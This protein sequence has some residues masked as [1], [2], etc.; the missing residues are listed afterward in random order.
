MKEHKK[1]YKS[2]KLWMT[3]TIMA[4]A[5]GT[6]MA[7][8][9]AHADAT[10]VTNTTSESQTTDQQKATLQKDIQDKQQQ[11]SDK[12]SQAA[13]L[14]SKIDGYKS[15][16]NDENT[17]YQNEQAQI[18][19]DAADKATSVDSQ[20]NGVNTSL[21]GAKQ[22]VSNTQSQ[23]NNVNSQI[24]DLQKAQGTTTSTDSNI[25]NVPNGQ[26]D[27]S[28]SLLENAARND[29]WDN[30]YS[31][32]QSASS[33]NKKAIPQNI[34]ISPDNNKTTNHGVTAPIDFTNDYN[35]YSD[36]DQV[37][38]NTG[39]T[40]NQMRELSILLLNEL[41]H[42]REQRGLAPFVMT[43]DQFKRAMARAQQSSAA[44]LNHNESDMDAAL[45][46]WHSEN[47]AF[48][49]TNNGDNMMSLLYNANDS[50][51]SMLMADADSD[52]GHRDNFLDNGNYN[53]AFGFKL[54][55]NGYYLMTFDTTYAT[56]ADKSNDLVTNTINSYA[57][58]GPTKG[59]TITV[60]NTAKINQLKDQLASLNQSLIAK[61]NQV[62]TLQ[63][64]LNDLNNQKSK[65]SSD[66]Q[67]KLAD[68]TTKHNAK[69]TD[70]NDQISTNQSKLDQL[71]ND[72]KDLKVVIAQDQ[73]AL[74]NLNKGGQT[75]VETKKDNEKYTNLDPSLVMKVNV[76]AGDT[77]IPAPKLADDAFIKDTNA[78]TASAAMFM[79]LAQT[80]GTYPEGT[81]VEWAD[82]AKVQKD[83]QTAGTYDEEVIL[84]FPDGTK[85]Q[86][87][88]VPGV[89]VVAAKQT[90][91]STDPTKP[92][93]GDDTHTTNPTK[94]TATEHT[95]TV[96]YIEVTGYAPDGKE[97]T[98][99]VGTQTF[100]G[101]QGDTFS[102]SQLNI[103]AG[104]KLA[105]DGVS[106]TIG[107]QDETNNTPV[108]S[109]NTPS[110]DHNN[111]PSTNPTTPTDNK[112]TDH[113]AATQLPAGAKVVNNQVVDAN[114]NVIAGWKVVNG[115]AVKSTDQ[116]VMTR[117]AYKAQQANNNTKALPQTGNND[118][119][120]VMGLGAA[121]L[122]GMFGLIGV[123]KKRN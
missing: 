19:K 2:G 22:D 33:W 48:V 117:E 26:I 99:V 78:N 80:N 108:V 70:L 12:A 47:L 10:L 23:I 73:T 72:I 49:S 110:D 42:A 62:N 77:N 71:N 120:A 93:T 69:L 113:N 79:V 98:K 37:N 34:Y 63:S 51:S 3:A 101:K 41:N 116:P 68:S 104:Y 50:I 81:K 122:L 75:P 53:A 67:T 118:N 89:L 15:Q 20:I 9:T 44:N 6:T 40:E 103:P 36:I 85:S 18:K 88:N 17:N 58:M 1:L 76:T 56:D 16:V 35:A 112:S 84:D 29:L 39:M 74:D 119:L 31:D 105:M 102:G 100:T 66:E 52:W 115:Q 14:Q 64:Q 111:Q 90:T 30:Y 87:F 95:L 32:E 86:A 91:P 57:A 25:V 43:E 83:A 94:P 45:G 96:H 38:T 7:T 11:V 54:L 5:A 24:S 8:T 59:S 114:G 21:E 55:D 97:I 92:N 4:L 107:D 13:N 46:N 121:T 65:I 109:V 106:Y 27:K 28:K 82:P 61:Q 60:D 123:N